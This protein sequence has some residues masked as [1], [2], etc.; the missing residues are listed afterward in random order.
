MRIVGV[1][2]PG[3][4][5]MLRIQVAH[6]EH[7]QL[8]LWR[9]GLVVRRWLSA[10]LVED[11]VVLTA[12]LSPR[13]PTSR[14]P[15]VKRRGTDADLVC[16][17]GE[18]PVLNQRLAAYAV[19]K[20]PLG[21]L[22]C[23]CSTK[24]AVPGLWQLPGGGLLAGES[25][26]DAVIR[27]VGEETGQ[28]IRIGRLLELQSDHWVGRAPNGV[29]EDFHALRIIYT[30]SCPEPT[31]PT[32]IDIDG[33]TARAAWVPLRRWRALPWTSGTRSLLDRYLDRIEP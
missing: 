22:G 28:Q 2:T 26:S 16:A 17:P 14:P 24:T 5:E 30:A 8:A 7:P 20:S 29:L 12:Q 1:S 27:E 15:R 21:V 11:E 18:V 32:V 23:E 4:P 9:Q 3:A 13:R 25:P 33:T 10:R 19:I 31:P 6:G